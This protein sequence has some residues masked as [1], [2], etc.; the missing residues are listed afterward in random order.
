MATLTAGLDFRHVASYQFAI[1]TMALNCTILSHGVGQT[2]R[3]T[4]RRTD[5]IVA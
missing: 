3:L 5:G 4:D 1:V 2:D